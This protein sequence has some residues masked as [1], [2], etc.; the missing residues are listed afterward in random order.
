MIERDAVAV[1]PT[2]SVTLIVNE[3]VPVVVGMPEI[4]PVFPV[5]YNPDGKL[6]EAMLQAYGGLP[7]AAARVAVYSL[8]TFPEG[9]EL[10]LIVGKPITALIVMDK[11]AVA[12]P[13]AASVVF[14]MNE[15]FPAIAGVPESAPLVASDNPAGR[16]PEETVHV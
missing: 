13:D 10:V 6:P 7:A 14:T 15:E 9:K 12:V 11:L 4:T 2:S 3:E 8:F 1:E 5:R 16:L